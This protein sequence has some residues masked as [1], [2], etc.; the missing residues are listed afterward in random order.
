VLWRH[1][2]GDIGAQTLRECWRRAACRDRNR[3][4]ALAM[5][6]RQDERAELWIV[7]DVAEDAEP[8][9]IVEDLPIYRAVRRRSND[10]PVAADVVARV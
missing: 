9:A 6:R 7:G 1:E 5:N 3:D 8:L 10:E 2:L 4:R